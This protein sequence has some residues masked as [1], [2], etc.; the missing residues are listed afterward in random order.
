MKN[1]SDAIESLMEQSEK[2][3]LFN[4]DLMEKFKELSNLLKNIIPQ[5]LLDNLNKT[6]KSLEKMDLKSLQE[7]LEN[8]SNNISEIESELDRYIDI[9]KRLQ[10]EQK[11]TELKNRLEK[12]IQQKDKLDRDIESFDNTSNDEKRIWQEELR[13][14]EE[15]TNINDEIQEAS[16]LIKPFSQKS[17]KRLDELKNSSDFNLASKNIENTIS[18]LKNKKHKICTIF[19]PI[20]IK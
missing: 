17:S 16:D 20:I 7:A 5:S 6:Q 2:H 8:M 19:K 13:G 14:L 3:E 9:F 1:I 4:S 15:L 12:L 18:E 10:A 11:L